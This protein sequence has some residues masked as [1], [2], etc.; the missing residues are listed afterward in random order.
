MTAAEVRAFN[1]GVRAALAMAKHIAD[2]IAA[3]SLRPL[4]D[5]FAVEA[6]DAFAEA[7]AALLLPE[8]TSASKSEGNYP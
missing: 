6:L 4:H 8:P 7:G 3:R 5:G 2:A 1:A